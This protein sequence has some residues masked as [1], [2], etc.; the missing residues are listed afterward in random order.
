MAASSAE[1]N[2]RIFLLGYIGTIKFFGSVDGTSGTWLGI[3]W[4]DPQRGKHDGAKDGI[5][6]FTCAWVAP[7]P[8]AYS[9]HSIAGSL[10]RDHSFGR[11]PLSNT[12]QPSNELSFLN[13]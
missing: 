8:V 11:R 12:G 10:G 5:Q 13:T 4:D 9:S 6:Y 3:E 2:T 1:I 7:Q